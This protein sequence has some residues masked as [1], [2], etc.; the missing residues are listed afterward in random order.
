MKR[1]MIENT[2]RT[3]ELQEQK[4]YLKKNQNYPVKILKF[5]IQRALN[6]GPINT[7]V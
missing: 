1:I 4:F 2:A 7:D 3:T 6:N 5:G